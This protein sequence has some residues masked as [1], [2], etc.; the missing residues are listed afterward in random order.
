MYAELKN[1]KMVVTF[2]DNTELV[3][4]VVLKDGSI[5]T[6]HSPSI[7]ALTDDEYV[8]KNAQLRLVSIQYHHI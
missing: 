6:S 8:K 4:M 3:K 5:V 2:H 7:T 1:K